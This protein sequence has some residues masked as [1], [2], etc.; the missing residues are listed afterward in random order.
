MERKFMTIKY[1]S[2]IKGIRDDIE[3]YVDSNQDPDFE[4]NEMIYDELELDDL[5]NYFIFLS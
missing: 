2:Q 5:G 3:Y 1:P 4:E